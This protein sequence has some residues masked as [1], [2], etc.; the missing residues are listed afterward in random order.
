VLASN[1]EDY[2]VSGTVRSYNPNNPVEL[3]LMQGTDIKY[4][5]FIE[6]EEGSGERDQE[7]R[8]NGVE[9]G[10]YTLVVMKEAHLKL[11]VH[12]VVVENKDVNLA[13]DTREPVQILTLKCGDLN[14][15]GQ[16]TSDDLLILL[17][18]YLES[19]EKIPADLNGD[20]QVNSSDL[21][22]LLGNYLESDIVVS[23]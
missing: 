10:I 21:L 17:G 11:T 18:S 4:R 1:T 19:G 6:A 8:F 23:Y 22:I 5:E 2:S 13:D 20:G 3:R 15:D 7:F 12:N 14:E 9:P 16:I